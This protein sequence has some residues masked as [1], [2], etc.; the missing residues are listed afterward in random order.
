MGHCTSGSWVEVLGLNYLTGLA[1]RV[2]VSEDVTYNY[3]I[4][5]VGLSK[6]E[7]K[8]ETHATAACYHDGSRRCG[9]AILPF[10]C[11]LYRHIGTADRV[12]THDGHAGWLI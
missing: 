10:R 12:S 9:N 8:E 4:W 6:E 7:G 5:Y 1:T 11:I 2:D 3:T